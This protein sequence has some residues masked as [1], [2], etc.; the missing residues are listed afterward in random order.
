M[1]VSTL[2]TG[3]LTANTEGGVTITDEMGR[4]AN[5]IAVDVQATN[6]VIHVIDKVLLP[7]IE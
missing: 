2:E 5:V 7:G 1:E 6:G 4:M 3:V